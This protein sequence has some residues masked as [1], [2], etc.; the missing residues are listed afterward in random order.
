MRCDRTRPVS[1]I[2]EDAATIFCSH[3]FLAGRA[4]KEGHADILVQGNLT[5]RF[6]EGTD[7]VAGE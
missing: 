1:V 7:D 3:H 5:F 6:T 4:F 2:T